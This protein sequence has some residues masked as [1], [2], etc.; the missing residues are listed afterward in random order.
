ML[1]LIKFQDW[2]K[3]NVHLKLIPAESLACWQFV[4]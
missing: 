3:S 1:L 4:L 2:N